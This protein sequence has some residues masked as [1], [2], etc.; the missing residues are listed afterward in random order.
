MP[1]DRS[2]AISL[3]EVSKRYGKVEAV[4]GVSLAIGEG[5][6]FSTNSIL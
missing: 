2:V 5:E 4:R 6:F 3:E 1:E